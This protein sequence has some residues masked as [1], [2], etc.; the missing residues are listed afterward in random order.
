M[1]FYTGDDKDED[2]E[3]E[4]YAK[5]NAYLQQNN[6]VLPPNIRKEEVLRNIQAAAFNYKNT[7]HNILHSIEWRK[8]SI[9]VRITPVVERIIVSAYSYLNISRTLASSMC[10][11]VTAI[12]AR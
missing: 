7:L 8:T 2:W 10:P 4:H 5:F 9:P 11:R 1:M 3:I 6:L 12:S